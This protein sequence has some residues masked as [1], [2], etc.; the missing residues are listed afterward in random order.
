MFFNEILLIYTDGLFY[1]KE[2][3]AGIVHESMTIPKAARPWDGLLAQ[4][5]PRPTAPCGIQ[6][7]SAIAMGPG[8]GA[9]API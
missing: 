9:I 1:A 6:S 2:F 4:H 8:G 7:K 3:L 5:L